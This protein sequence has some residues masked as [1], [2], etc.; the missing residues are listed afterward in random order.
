[1][2][3]RAAVASKIEAY[4]DGELASSIKKEY[5]KGKSVEMSGGLI[6]HNLIKGEIYSILKA[7]IRSN[8]LPMLVLDSDQKTWVE[9]VDSFYYPDITVLALPPRFYQ[10]P[11]GKIRKDVITN[12]LLIV[13]VLSEDTRSF[14][15]GEKFENYCTIP[16]FREYLLVE[17]EKKVWAKTVYLEDPEKGLMRVNTYVDKNDMIH[18][19][20]IDCTIKLGEIYEAIEGIEL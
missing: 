10:S 16:G 17:P 15:K 14:D 13:E 8:N 3:S 18:L 1:M 9:S 7:F 11:S 6:S 2:E 12:P 5:H 20:S 4:L 19:N